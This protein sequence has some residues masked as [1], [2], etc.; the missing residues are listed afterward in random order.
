MPRYKPVDYAQMQWIPIHF[1]TQILP[2]SFEYALDW[3]VEHKLDL[4]GFAA[5]YKNDDV[6]AP[7]YDPRVMLK[8][9]LAAYAHGIISSR[10][11]ERACRENVVFMALSAGTKPHFT[12]IAQFIRGLG[13]VV[14][15]LFV[16]VLLY[17]DE[18]GLIGKEMFAVDGCKLSSAASKE[19]SGTRA[20]FEKKRK[21]FGECIERLVKKHRAQDETG[22]Q[23]PAAGMR[24]S[25]TSSIE[26]MRAKMEK[27]DGWLKEHPE[28]KKGATDKPVKSSMTDPDSAKMVSS[29]GVVQGYNGL[30]VV[31]AKRQVIVGAEA[32]GTGSEAG[33]LK[34]LVEQVKSTFRELGDED[35]YK[36]AK[37]TADSAFHSEDALKVLADNGVDGY[38]PDNNFRKRDPSFADAARHRGRPGALAGRKRYERKYFGPGDF[39]LDPA[40]G[41][42][43]C[44]AGNALYVKDR[45]FKTANGFHGTAY[46]AKVTDCRA[47]PLRAKCLRLPHTPA[48]QVHKFAGRDVPPAEESFSRRMIQKIDT[49]VGRFLYSRRMGI[50]EPVFANLRHMLGLDRFT[51]RGKAK[52]DVQWKL[53]ALVHNLFKVRRY[54]WAGAG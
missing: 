50:V 4:A 29:H 16:D 35:V 48:R 14:Q 6:G 2:D 40:T 38:V 49:A 1:P 9:V 30:A 51:L 34:P 37:M 18:L 12:T 3:I 52:V 46:M 24:S 13:D 11:I 19:W 7:A 28:D 21:S 25:E 31:D 8:I 43:V 39:I 45:N 47:C 33:L 15:K 20:D 17:C 5:H 26:K 53:Y 44:P 42:L 41:K 22:E 32:F 54:G 10:D 36:T 23:E 27:I